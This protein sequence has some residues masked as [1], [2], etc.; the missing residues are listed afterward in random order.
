[1]KRLVIFCLFLFFTDIV[2]SQQRFEI[3]KCGYGF[4]HVK[5]IDNG[6][7]KEYSQKGYLYGYQKLKL[8]DGQNIKVRNCDNKSEDYI[9]SSLYKEWKSKNIDD[10][11][12]KKDKSESTLSMSHG[13][14]GSVVTFHQPFKCE[15]RINNE[16]RVALI[17]GNVCYSSYSPLN[18]ASKEALDVKEK[19]LNLG[20]DCYLLTNLEENNFQKTIENFTKIVNQDNYKVALLYYTGHGEEDKEG[21][22]VL[23]PV[24]ADTKGNGSLLLDFIISK[25]QEKQREGENRLMF[26]NACRNK[27]S[28][29]SKNDDYKGTKIDNGS[30]LVQSTM[31]GEVTDVTSPKSPKYSPFTIAFINS[32]GD[33]DEYI[34]KTY[35]RIV[36]SVKA[37]GAQHQP[38]RN[39]HNVNFKFYVPP[40]KNI[41]LGGIDASYWLTSNM[42]VIDVYG[43][44]EWNKGWSLYGGARCY[45]GESEKLYTNNSD[46]PFTPSETIFGR[47]FGLFVR[48]GYDISHMIFKK[49]FKIRD[50][51]SLTLYGEVSFVY[52]NNYSWGFYYSPNFRL[53][54][55][56]T[57]HWQVHGDLG[58]EF[59]FP[60][61]KEFRDLPKEASCKENIFRIQFGVKY[62]F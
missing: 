12:E 24:D 18:L 23:L 19:L 22:D 58:Y 26:I 55:N 29:Y 8:E 47:K 16:K 45:I 32:I 34:E 48:G 21:H 4:S 14:P 6:K 1:M 28:N 37:Y 7:E 40:K 53:G 2:C 5:A 56:I 35:D 33:Y 20:F 59:N 11:F 41:L 51:L 9:E 27:N 30:Y 43:G 36:S 31:E 54:Y 61:N 3:L 10:Y 57:N 60:L 38:Q 49:G 52:A 13:G 25:M 15:R 17:I 46:L 39:G 50:L 42:C 62:K 44:L